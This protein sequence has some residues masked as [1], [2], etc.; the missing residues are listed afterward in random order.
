MSRCE[1]LCTKVI[2]PPPPPAIGEELTLTE[3]PK[4]SPILTKDEPVPK[5]IGEAPV[6]KKRKF[7]FKHGKMSVKET[8]FV[9]PDNIYLEV[10]GKEIEVSE[11]CLLSNSQHFTRVL[12][13]ISSNSKSEYLM[14]EEDYDG[15]K[16]EEDDGEDND[17]E[18]VDDTFSSVSYE[19]VSSVINFIAKRISDL[20]LSEVNVSQVQ[21]VAR[22]LG[23]NT[24]EKITKKF[25]RTGLSLSNCFSRFSLADSFLGWSETS[26]MIQTF[27]EFHF[28]EILTNNLDDF[29]AKLNEIQLKRI[30]ASSNLHIRSEDEVME[31]VLAWVRHDPEARGQCLAPL[32]DEVQVECL[33]GA[34]KVRKL[35][36]TDLL[37]ADP[38]CVEILEQGLEY[39]ELS[40]EDKVG[41]I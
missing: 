7:S 28:S 10:Q 6:S 30:L 4:V 41:V 34:E 2:K 12:E 16:Y 18:D 22:L 17:E 9:N 35:L 13:D 1:P 39:H 24:V 3:T 19:S 38:H 32:M 14:Q 36:N 31:A 40:N 23:I 8:P 29:C 26:S 21:H 11:S 15:E 37:A 20:E 25:V 27:I 33:S 5:N